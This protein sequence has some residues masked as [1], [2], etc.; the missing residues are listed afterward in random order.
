M[1]Y[2][3]HR[4]DEYLGVASLEVFGQ[5]RCLCARDNRRDERGKFILGD[6][7]AD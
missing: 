2:L 5:I 4:I 3:V 1:Y 6:S 7:T